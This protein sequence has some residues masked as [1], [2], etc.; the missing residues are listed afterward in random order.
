MLTSV[1]LH[2]ILRSMAESLLSMLKLSSSVMLLVAR[3]KRSQG[4]CFTL[5]PK[6]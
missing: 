3:V 2:P 5:L 6:C 1:L 4:T